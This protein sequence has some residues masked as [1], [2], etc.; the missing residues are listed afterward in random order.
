MFTAPYCGY[1]GSGMP[2]NLNTYCPGCITS[3]S[4]AP[5]NFGGTWLLVV[6]GKYRY[7]PSNGNW[8]LLPYHF[9]KGS[10]NCFRTI[11]A[12]LSNGVAA[13]LCV[14]QSPYM[15]PVYASMPPCNLY[16]F[17]H[18]VWYYTAGVGWNVLGSN[19]PGDANN[20]VQGYSCDAVLGDGVLYVSGK[21]TAFSDGTLCDIG[22]AAYS[23]A[24]N[25]WTCLTGI[26]KSTGGYCMML[27]YASLPSGNGGV[28]Y[29]GCSSC[30]LYAGS[31]TSGTNLGYIAAYKTLD[32]LWHPVVAAGQT[33][34]GLTTGSIY[35]MTATVASSFYKIFL[36]PVIVP[37]SRPLVPSQRVPQSR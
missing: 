3:Y 6:N 11:P 18:L 16:D 34:L 27:A 28:L 21:F 15:N 4:A 9:W 36:L 22:I 12:T 17:K 37:G 13:L 10:A 19:P 32:G 26:T 23:I 2:D 5:F 20:N 29:A 1:T 25:T 8:D 31:S 35:A 7:N 30:S 33:A 24:T 14:F